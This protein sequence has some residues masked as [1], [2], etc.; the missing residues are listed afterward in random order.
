MLDLKDKWIWDF[1]FYQQGDMHHIF[2]LQA[3]RSLGDPDLRHWNATIGHAVSKDLKNW[4]RLTDAFA[5]NASGSIINDTDPSV[6]VA[7][8]GTAWTGSIVQHDGKYWQ[9][10]TGTR[11]GEDRLIQRVMLAQSNDLI[12]WTR[13]QPDAVVEY[14]PRWYETLDL[15]AWHDQAWRDPWVMEDPET[16]G[17]W[18]M[19]ITARAK[20][21]IADG[22]GVVAHATSSDLYNWEVH[23]PVTK[24]GDY[25]EMEVPQVLEIS[26]RFYLIFSVRGEMLSN[27]HR[28]RIGAENALTGV[29]YLVSDKIEGPYHSIG[30][31]VLF[32]DEAGSLYSGKLLYDNNDQLSLIAFYHMD[33]EGRF[34][35]TVTDP[36]PV[37]VAP[38]G[39]LSVD[40]NHVKPQSGL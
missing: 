6:E 3:N 23:P 31:G 14:D 38:D 15:K 30:D 37:K 26:G 19:F 29:R 2:F 1:W 16:P 5:P 7:D 13:Y 11:T 20:D 18:H 40:P 24:S 8:S 10:Y 4:T 12:H 21:G 22:R 27:Q 25:G 28:D 9:F 33:K 32:T 36:I 17:K 34:I 39:Q 35:G